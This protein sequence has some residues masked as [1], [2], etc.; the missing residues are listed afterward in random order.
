MATSLP[1]VSDELDTCEVELGKTP[2]DAR[3]VR[4][5]DFDV[6]TASGPSNR[7]LRS[8]NAKAKKIIVA[9]AWVSLSE[10]FRWAL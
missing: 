8:R 9:S 6:S 10:R 2:A 5:D 7:T 3:D 4:E 1:T